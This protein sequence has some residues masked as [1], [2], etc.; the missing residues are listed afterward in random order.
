MDNHI[1]ELI[2]GYALDSLDREERLVV[3]RHVSRCESCRAELRGYNEVVGE[4]AYALTPIEPPHDLKKQI[5]SEIRVRDQSARRDPGISFWQKLVNYSRDASPAWA[6]ASILLILVLGFGN[7][8]MWKQI[9]ELSQAQATTNLA[10]INLNGTGATP[11]AIGLIIVSKDGEHGT[12]IVDRLPLL[13]ESKQYQLWLIMD[14][15]RTSGGVFSVSDDGYGSMWVSSS[16]PLS[17]F[18]SFGITIEPYGGSPGPTGE[19]VLGSDA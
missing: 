18:T 6:V 19:K 8:F 4:L 1:T 13:E 14:S 2:P 16:A 5:M 7:L 12:L 15:K 17:S 11:D 10:V 3:E 9:N